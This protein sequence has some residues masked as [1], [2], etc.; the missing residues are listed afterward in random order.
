MLVVEDTVQYEALGDGNFLLGTK[1]EHDTILE[2]YVPRL[3][4]SPVEMY[5]EQKAR[6]MACPSQDS[7]TYRVCLGR[8]PGPVTT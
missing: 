7:K 8:S 6:N 5:D 4:M 3:K 1:N 2:A